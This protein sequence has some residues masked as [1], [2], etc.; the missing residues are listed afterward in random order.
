MTDDV[1]ADM[2]A[3]RAFYAR[4]GG[5]VPARRSEPRLR[6]E[7]AG[8]RAAPLSPVSGAASPRR[9][10]PAPLVPFR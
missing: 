3:I 8:R 9:D 4:F 1:R 7:D 10:G 5:V 6:E 2:D